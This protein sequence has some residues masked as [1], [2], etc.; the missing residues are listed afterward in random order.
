MK[1]TNKSIN[2][3]TFQGYQAQYQ[4]SVKEEDKYNQCKD[5]IIAI[6]FHY[7]NN[8]I[9]LIIITTIKNKEE[10]LKMQTMQTMQG[11]ILKT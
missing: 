11:L 9:S 10:D 5:L 1:A 6:N 3:V 8:N 4:N 7:Y 2:T